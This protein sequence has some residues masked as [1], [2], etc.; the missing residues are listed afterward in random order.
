MPAFV[1]LEIPFVVQEFYP[2]LRVQHPAH[3]T[4][5]KRKEFM[6]AAP[7]ATLRRRERKAS[8]KA[9]G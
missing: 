2:P 9:N 4:Q 5:N 6:L 3:A 1:A 8:V 7:V